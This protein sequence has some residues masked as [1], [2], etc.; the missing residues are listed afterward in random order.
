MRVQSL[1]TRLIIDR[2]HEFKDN[3]EWSQLSM[4][5]IISWD[6]IRE[7]INVFPWDWEFVSANPSIPLDTIDSNP[8]Y[9]WS[10]EGLSYHPHLTFDYICRYVNEDWDW[11]NITMH[12][13]I[14]I[15]HILMS[16]YL[17]WDWKVLHYN[18]NIIG[19]L[20]QPTQHTQP[21]FPVSDSIWMTEPELEKIV[22]DVHPFNCSKVTCNPNM[23]YHFFKKHLY[24]KF[25]NWSS[26]WSQLSRN[27]GLLFSTSDAIK[28]CTE[29]FAA[30]KIQ[31]AWKKCITDPDF[32]LCRQR[33]VNEFNE[34][35]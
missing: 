9:P 17:P 18:P 24:H 3:W 30:Q 35:C 4:N 26:N 5:P 21:I 20:S 16:P 13:N 29:Y 19:R 11:T 27:Q 2:I 8:E 1:K 14:H 15:E 23:T 10:W 28:L 7:T 6:V 33:L 25:K 34:M 22:Q 31:K 12:K 32:K